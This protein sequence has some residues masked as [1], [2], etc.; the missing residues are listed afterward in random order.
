MRTVG[1]YELLY[2]IGRGGMAIVYLARQIELDRL[3]ALKELSAFHADDPVGPG[4]EAPAGTVGPLAILTR[5]PRSAP[6]CVEA[7]ARLWSRVRV[8]PSRKR[9]DRRPANTIPREGDRTVGIRRHVA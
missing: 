4:S 5:T 8:R 2:E 1:R 3:V 9:I 6:K 7:T